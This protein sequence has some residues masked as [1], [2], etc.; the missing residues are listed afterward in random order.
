MRCFLG[1][2]PILLVSLFPLHALCEDPAKD[3]QETEAEIRRLTA[4][5]QV[6]YLLNR[7]ALNEGQ[8]KTLLPIAAEARD[9]HFAFEKDLAACRVEMEK[10]FL[11]LKAEDEAERGLS[12]EVTSAAVRANDKYKDLEE[13]FHLRL[14]ALASKAAT[15]LSKEQAEA[16]KAFKCPVLDDGKVRPEALSEKPRKNKEDS[17]EEK[18]LREIRE[19]PEGGLV[20][21]EG[22]L[23]KLQLGREEA[24]RGEPYAEK[25]RK[26]REAAVRVLFR[27]ARS[28]SG[29][30]FEE[31]LE[32]LAREIRPRTRLE[33]LQWSMENLEKGERPGSGTIEKVLLSPY[34]AEIM[35]KRLEKKKE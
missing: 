21:I 28:I 26:D 24:K 20:R 33:E 8:M 31:A 2:L 16:A 12:K 1:G 15:I 7:L 14:A 29:E 10:A 11:A 23:V 30:E 32:G 3:G 18:L 17:R 5:I 25:A 35:A 22:E 13:D 6:L 34:S 9:L 27:K 4:E 19:A